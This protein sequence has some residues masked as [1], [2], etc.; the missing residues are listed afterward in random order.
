MIIDLEH[1]SQLKQI[2]CDPKQH[3][4]LCSYYEVTEAKQTIKI[5]T[6]IINELENKIFSLEKQ[7]LTL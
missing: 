3:V 4:E 1:L 6:E 7:N 5:L 2:V